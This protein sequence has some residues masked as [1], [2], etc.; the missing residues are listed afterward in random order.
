MMGQFSK[1]LE[2]IQIIDSQGFNPMTESYSARIGQ[3]PVDD[4]PPMTGQQMSEI[5]T[6]GGF[7]DPTATLV[8]PDGTLDL[9]SIS[10]GYNTIIDNPDLNTEGQAWVDYLNTHKKE[11]E[12]MYYPDAEY[13]IAPNKTLRLKEKKRPKNTKYRFE[14]TYN[15]ATNKDVYQRFDEKTGEHISYDTKE[16]YED[17]IKKYKTITGNDPTKGKNE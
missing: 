14:K 17:A 5:F 12:Q 3:L 13:E 4:D 11:L 7:D 8:T 15:N 16:A 10:K 1:M 6:G 9:S 2:Q